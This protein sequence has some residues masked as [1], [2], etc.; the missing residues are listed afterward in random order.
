[1]Q[2][3]SF[4]GITFIFFLSWTVAGKL[5]SLS[6][7]HYLFHTICSCAAQCQSIWVHGWYSFTFPL[8]YPSCLVA[9]GLCKYNELETIFPFYY[10]LKDLYNMRTIFLLKKFGSSG[11]ETHSI[12]HATTSEL[13]LS[14]SL[15]F[16]K[17]LHVKLIW[18]LILSVGRF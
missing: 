16:L 11:D 3:K 1:M 12:W 5:C 9:P 14:S 8:L 18:S 6:I 15:T 17:N 13:H 2:F 7:V 10:F 4:S